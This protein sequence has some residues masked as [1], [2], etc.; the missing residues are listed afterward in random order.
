MYNKRR[1]SVQT[2]CG[3]VRRIAFGSVNDNLKSIR[4]IKKAKIRR[5]VRQNFE[6]DMNAFDAFV[7]Q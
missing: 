4:D 1:S 2:D 7:A 5:E 6:Q 3:S